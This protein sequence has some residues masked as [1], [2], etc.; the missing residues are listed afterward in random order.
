MAHHFTV[1]QVFLFEIRSIHEVYKYVRNLLDDDEP[2]LEEALECYEKATENFLRLDTRLKQMRPLPVP[3]SRGR[4]ALLHRCILL[5][6]RF[7]AEGEKEQSGDGDAG[8]EEG[9]SSSEPRK[10]G[11]TETGEMGASGGDSS[12]EWI[13]R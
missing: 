6:R 12:S 8:M 3:V 4:A 10:R 11:V 9:G 7:K 2:R 5:Q 13:Y 1:E